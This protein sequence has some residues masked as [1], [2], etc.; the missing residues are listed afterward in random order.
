MW[1]LPAYSGALLVTVENCSFLLTV[2]AFLL[3]TLVFLTCNWSFLAYSGEV[4][5]TRALRDC[6]QRS[7]TVSKEAPTV[8]KKELPPKKRVQ[9]C[10]RHP[11]KIPGTFQIPLFETRGRQTFEGGHELFGHHPFASKTPIPPGGLRTQ[12]LNLCALCLIGPNFGGSFVY[13]WGRLDYICNSKT[14]KSVS[15]I[16]W[17]LI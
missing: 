6:K 11:S 8:S 17:K 16:F 12:K 1:K 4:R 2:G 7:L 13:P 15:V 9:T 5:L 3:T 10:E 14:N